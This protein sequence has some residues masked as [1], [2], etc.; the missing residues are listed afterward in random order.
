[1]CKADRSEICFK[2][3]F[4]LSYFKQHYEKREIRKKKKTQKNAKTTK[5]TQKSRIKLYVDT[6]REIIKIRIM[7]LVT[8]IFCSLHYERNWGFKIFY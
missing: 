5:K 7:F 8:Y 3:D 6:Q 2:S 1:M 4:S